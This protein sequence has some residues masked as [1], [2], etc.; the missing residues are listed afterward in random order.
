MVTLELLVPSAQLAGKT[1]FRAATRSGDLRGRTI[2]LYDNGKP[3]GDIV[4]RRLSERL[5]EAF[6]DVRFKTYTGSVGGRATLT[7][8]GAKD[9]AAECAAVI[10]IRGD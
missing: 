1:A 7:A 3:G 9:I 4:Q 10:G 2:A 5:P 8:A 6:A